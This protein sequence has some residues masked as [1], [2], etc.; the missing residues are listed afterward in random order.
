[1]NC[2][3]RSVIA[4]DIQKPA[5]FGK[6]MD[7]AVAKGTEIVWPKFTEQYDQTL[8]SLFFTDGTSLDADLVVVAIGDDARRRFP[9][10]GR[11]HRE[12]VDR[13][14]RHRPDLGRQGLRHRRRDAGSAS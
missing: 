2:G 4:V 1:M 14:Q 6:E 13:R 8:K 5:A 11:P 10:A 9:P 12:G 7:L 3:A